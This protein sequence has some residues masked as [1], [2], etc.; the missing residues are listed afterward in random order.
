MIDD[1][2]R[3]ASTRFFQ[4]IEPPPTASPIGATV[5]DT[6]IVVSVSTVEGQIDVRMPLA[7]AKHLT[8]RLQ[9]AVRGAQN[10]NR[11]LRQPGA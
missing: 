9:D 2:D 4:A 10:P 6:D 1:F 11:P 7:F 3:A 8:S 5:E